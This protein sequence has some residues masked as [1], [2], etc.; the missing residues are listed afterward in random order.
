[1]IKIKDKLITVERIRLQLTIKE[2]VLSEEEY[3]KNRIFFG[4][5]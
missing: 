4:F 2:P 3:K 1:M 5:M